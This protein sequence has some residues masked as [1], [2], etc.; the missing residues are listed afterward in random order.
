MLEIVIDKKVQSVVLLTTPGSEF[1][2]KSISNLQKQMRGANPGQ[3][4]GTK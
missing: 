2:F 3:C 1:D 4:R